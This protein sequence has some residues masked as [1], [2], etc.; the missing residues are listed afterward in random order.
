MYQ[1]IAPIEIYVKTTTTTT[2]PKTEPSEQKTDH[3][4][5]FQQRVCFFPPLSFCVRGSPP[6]EDNDQAIGYRRETQSGLQSAF[7]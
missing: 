3:R 7:L 4:S 5:G 1:Q 2:K 6:R